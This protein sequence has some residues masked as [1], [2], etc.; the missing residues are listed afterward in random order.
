MR[1]RIGLTIADAPEDRFSHCRN[2][3]TIGKK[4]A[5]SVE[6]GTI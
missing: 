3:L 2:G 1:R 4:L 5:G 6:A